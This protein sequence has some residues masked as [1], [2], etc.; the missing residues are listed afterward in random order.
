MEQS[1][2]GRPLVHQ[3]D[4]RVEQR[5]ASDECREPFAGGGS[6]RPVSGVDRP[7]SDLAGGEHVDVVDSEV[8]SRQVTAVRQR[9]AQVVDDAVRLLIIGDERLSG[10]SPESRLSW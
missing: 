4:T 9:S 8:G 2:V 1:Q 3:T 6:K 5:P 7:L 10:E